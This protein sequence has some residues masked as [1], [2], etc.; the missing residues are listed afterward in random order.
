MDAFG[1]V[2]NVQYYRYIE[3]SRILYSKIKY[4]DSNYILLLLQVMQNI[5]KICVLS[6]R[7]ESR[8][9]AEELRKSAFRYGFIYYGVNL[10][11]NQAAT[12]EAVM[13][14]VE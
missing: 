12:G 2:N 8:V 4:I 11:A 10:S 6:R 3:S 1:H 5:L 7:I 14:C 9:R 13:V